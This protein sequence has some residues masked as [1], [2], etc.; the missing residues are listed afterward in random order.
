MTESVSV[1]VTLVFIQQANPVQLATEIGIIDTPGSFVQTDADD[2]NGS[3]VY[4]VNADIDPA[5]IT[6]AID[7]HT[8]TWSD[9][10]TP[11]V[12]KWI[13]NLIGVPVIAPKRRWWQFR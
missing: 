12:R 9:G 13:D 4:L 11:P 7:A 8:P 10:E 5:R 6:A 1:P 3:W 2:I